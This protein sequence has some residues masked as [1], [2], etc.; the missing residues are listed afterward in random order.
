MFH[1]FY[2]S[3]IRLLAPF[4]RVW[5]RGS[6]KHRVLS[7]RFAPE[8]PSF[9]ARPLWVHACSVGEVNTA[10]PLL[11]VL[12]ERFPAMPLVLSV[13]TAAGHALARERCALPVVWCPFDHP[14]VVSRFLAG[15]QPRGLVLVETELWPNLVRECVR[16]A[17]PVIVA[18]ARLSD[19]HFPRY[20]RLS[21][22][23]R[24]TFQSLGAVSAQSEVHAKRFQALGVPED[25]V[26]VTGSTKFDSVVNAVDPTERK[27][28]R[29]SCGIPPDVPV[30]VFGSTRPG[31]EALAASCW[32]TLRDAVPGLRLIVAPRHA[33]RMDEVLT[34]FDEPVIRRSTLAGAA[35]VGEEHIL[36]VDTV[37]E[38]V[39]FYSLA[40][41]AVV[42]GSF[43]PGV[44][45]HNPIEPCALGVPTVFGPF[46]AN[47]LEPARTLLAASGAIQ[48]ESPHA[49]CGVLRRL[50]LNAS[51]ARQLGT[52]ARKAVLD[53][54]GAIHRNV[55]LI[56]TAL[57]ETM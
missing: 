37:G 3:A 40:T 9:R 38:L 36:I 2:N 52:R 34:C 49:L 16:R 4:L 26:R 44:E 17:V 1:F 18:N 35:R 53:N 5:L 56:G 8:V 39:R 27:R 13:S 23:W 46:M 57:V 55:D 50:L 11:D 43:Y 47:F 10:L 45:G 51:E 19:K 21:F 33:A 14:R 24:E 6:R 41:V 29:R 12:A 32:R 30:L 48:V 28:L 54:R 22:F 20:R 7:A 31:D 15:M 42:G 25:R